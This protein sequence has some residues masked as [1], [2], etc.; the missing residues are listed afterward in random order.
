MGQHHGEGG[1]SP[2]RRLS[3]EMQCGHRTLS[4]ETI[5][6]DSAICFRRLLPCRFAA[7]II[8]LAHF[9]SALCIPLSY[10]RLRVIVS[11]SAYIA[12]VSSA[13]CVFSVFLLFVDVDSSS[14]SSALQIR[15]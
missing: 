9:V 12:G 3:C 2:R 8:S 10:F 4:L 13:S 15:K 5:L 6:G 7:F 1:S 11:A 14:Q